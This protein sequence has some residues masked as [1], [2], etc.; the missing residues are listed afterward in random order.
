MAPKLISP[1]LRKTASLVHCMLVDWMHMPDHLASYTL[2][3]IMESRFARPTQLKQ[4]LA[5]LQTGTGDLD[6]F[7]DRIATPAFVVA[8]CEDLAVEGLLTRSQAT[9]AEHYALAVV[10]KDG[11]W[12]GETA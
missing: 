4:H 6:H 3:A 11:Q 2:A 1:A 10:D 7:F 5:I 12:K 9:Q 8:L